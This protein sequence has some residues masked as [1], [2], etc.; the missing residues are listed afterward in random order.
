MRCLH[1]KCPMKSG[2]PSWDLV[3]DSNDVSARLVDRARL[4]ATL[5]TCEGPGTIGY[6]DPQLVGTA[7]F[8]R[9]LQSSPCL[10]SQLPVRVTARAV[11][12]LCEVTLGSRITSA[13]V[14]EAF[15]IQHP[16]VASRPFLY[17]PIEAGAGGGDIM[18]ALCAEV[19]ANHDLPP[20]QSSLDG[21]PI[22]TT[23]AHLS[24][25]AGKMNALK[26][27]G[28]I[29]IPAAPHNILVSVKSEA[30]RERFIVSGNRLES[31]GFGFFNDASE[32]WSTNRM[33]LLK[34]WGFIAVYLPQSTLHAIVEELD[35]R[36]TSS[37]AI[38]LNGRPLFRPLQEFGD[39]MFR[40]SGGLTLE[41]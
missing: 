20:M 15:E 23:K 17:P 32:F 7:A 13:N 29:L 10:Y 14:Y 31:V 35:R 2:L 41:L 40:V 16:N 38:N 37:H 3:V 21:W 19:L 5:N 34:R 24:L 9:V 12:H 36:H 11:V 8:Q 39:D 28:D 18:E 26:L 30:A 6:V 25:N 1:P 4:L 33:N 27:Y 22:W